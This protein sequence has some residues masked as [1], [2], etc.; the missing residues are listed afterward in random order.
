MGSCNCCLVMFCLTLIGMGGGEA[1]IS[2][3]AM[4]ISADVGVLESFDGED[5][6]VVE[7]DPSRKRFLVD[8]ES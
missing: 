4:G 5:V 1:R 8:G 2:S 6:D 3:V 7:P